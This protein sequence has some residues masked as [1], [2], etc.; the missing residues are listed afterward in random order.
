MEGAKLDV[1]QFDHGPI[2]AR[3]RSTMVVDLNKNLGAK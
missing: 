2:T 1:N 3:R